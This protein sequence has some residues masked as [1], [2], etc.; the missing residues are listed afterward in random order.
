MGLGLCVGVYGQMGL[1]TILEAE[2]ALVEAAAAKGQKAAFVEFLTD[3]SIIFRPDAING[4]D[5]WIRQTEPAG[6]NL[7]RTTKL[8][9]VAA[10]GLLGYTTGSWQLKRKDKDVDVVTQGNYVT[11]WERRNGAGFRAVID[12]S[13]RHDEPAAS[14]LL[15]ERKNPSVQNSNKFGWSPADTAMKFLRAGMTGGGLAHAYDE[16]A[17]EDVVLLIDREPP[18]VGRKRA[19]KETKRFTSTKFP[20]KVAMYQAADMAYFW[21]QCHYANSEEGQ[22]IGNCLQILKL[23][24]NKWYIV[25]GV[26]ARV[27]SEKRPVL[28]QK[29]TKKKN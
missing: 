29:P 7:T 5:F 26:F 24:K 11:I 4:K 3:D 17:D 27:A 16:Y 13:I 9:D 22:E 23:R 20:L 8:A 14:D 1:N 15:I 2:R 6:S 21:N 25:L 18:I 19:I 28:Q 10:N 12:I